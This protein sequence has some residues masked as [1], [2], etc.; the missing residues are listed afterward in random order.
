MKRN[1]GTVPETN[2]VAEFDYV[3]VGQAARAAYS[4]I[5]SVPTPTTGYF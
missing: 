4:P 5:G 1:R 2:P 3:I